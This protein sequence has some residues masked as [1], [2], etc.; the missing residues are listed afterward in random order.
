MTCC[1]LA[2]VRRVLVALSL[3]CAAVPGAMAQ[4]MGV[5]ESDILVID[6]DRLFA[7]TQLGL[8][9]T[10]TLRAEREA[11]IARNRELESQL[12]AEEKALTDLRAQ[13]SP[14]EFRK[15]ADT[16]DSKVQEIRSQ[17]ERRARDLE[18]NSSQATVQFMRLIEPVLVQI[19]RE[20]GAA[21]VMDS[22]NVLL[23]A[24]A[25]DITDL[26]ITRIDERIGDAMPGDTPPQDATPVP[27]TPE[28]PP[29]ED[30]PAQ[31]APAEQ[32]PAGD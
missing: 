8:R 3:L 18:R 16:F 19:M 6:P 15:L 9:M 10:S 26:A 7:E 25:I 27:D 17:S 1:G 29:E 12:E 2:V 31:D 21:V 4:D 30:P 32:P 5:I 13:T 14:E 23:R 24:G 11:L 28:Q 20:A 22:R